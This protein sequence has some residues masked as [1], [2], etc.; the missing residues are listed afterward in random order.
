MLP[1]DDSG[2]IRRARRD[3]MSIRQIARQFEHSRKTVR[4]ALSH[5]EP[6]PAP[7]TRERNAPLMGPVEPI[8]DQILIDDET[9]PPKQRHTA[10]QVFRRLRDE[11]GYRGGYAQVQRYLL[12]HGRRERETFIPLG[13]LPA[14]GLRR[15]LVTSTSTFPRAGGKSLFS[16]PPGP[17]RTIPSLWPGHLPTKAI[18]EGTV[19]ALSSWLRPKGSLGGQ[20]QDSRDVDPPGASAPTSSPLRCTGQSLRLRSPLLHA[21]SGQRETRC[22]EH[23]QGRTTPLRHPGPQSEGPR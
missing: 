20:P 11:H 15:I 19:T 13:H 12:K 14:N 2:A 8:I 6:P 21:G 9:A 22:R 16:S 1:V 10:A 7:R 4:H 3:G 17:T 5:A 18:L 23:R